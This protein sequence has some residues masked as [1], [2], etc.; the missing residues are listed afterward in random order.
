MYWKPLTILPKRSILDVWQGSEY[1]FAIFHC[2]K[3]NYIFSKCDQTRKKILM[4]NF[5]FCPVLFI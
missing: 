4:E 5:I 2:T 3:N 1:A